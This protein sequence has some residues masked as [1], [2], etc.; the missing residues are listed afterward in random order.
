R[1]LL[2]IVVDAAHRTIVRARVDDLEERVHL[3]HRADEP[4]VERIERGPLETQ[5]VAAVARRAPQ[6]VMAGHEVREAALGAP[7]AL[8]VG[9]D[10]DEET[11]DA[12]A[13]RRAVSARI[14]MHELVARAGRELASFFLD[15]A[16]ARRADR[17]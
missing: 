12:G 2:H 8:A 13:L 3:A 9:V 5:R 17:P 10:I 4:A 1:V 15:R 16:E 14:D 11:Q 7:D 6:R